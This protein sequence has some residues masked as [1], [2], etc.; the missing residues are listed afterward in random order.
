M[1]IGERRIDRKGEKQKKFEKSERT[2]D[3]I[4]ASKLNEELNF[5][6]YNY[7]VITQI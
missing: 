7:V 4:E 2:N 5:C 3:G 6:V 1:W